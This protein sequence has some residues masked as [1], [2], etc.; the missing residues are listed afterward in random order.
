ML[1]NTS[2]LGLLFH[3]CAHCRAIQPQALCICELNSIATVESIVL[4]TCPYSHRH[5]AYVHIYS[6]ESRSNRHAYSTQQKFDSSLSMQF[7]LAFGKNTRENLQQRQRRPQ[8][9]QG[10]T[11]APRQLAREHTSLWGEYQCSSPSLEGR[12]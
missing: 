7:M 4:C 8:P 1:I 3:C 5:C 12:A 11:T 9:A 10:N 2:G 6:V